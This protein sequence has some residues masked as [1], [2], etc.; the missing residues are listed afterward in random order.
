MILFML[1]SLGA[2]F[3]TVASVSRLLWQFCTF[4]PKPEDSNLCEQTLIHTIAKDR[5]LPLSRFLTQ[6]CSLTITPCTVMYDLG[7]TLP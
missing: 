7:L 3:N 6:V 1:T 2:Y 4:K 5:G